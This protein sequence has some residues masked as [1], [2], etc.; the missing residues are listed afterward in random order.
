L[1]LILKV[2]LLFDFERNSR[3]VYKEL[4]VWPTINLDFEPGGC[5]FTVPKVS[6][7]KQQQT[8]S[9]TVKQTREG[10]EADDVS[11]STKHPLETPRSVHYKFVCMKYFVHH[12]TSEL[13]IYYC[14]VQ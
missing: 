6:E 1:E 4:S 10:S 2:I 12:M 8:L 7:K 11:R 5:P 3:P 14:K 13:A 9:H